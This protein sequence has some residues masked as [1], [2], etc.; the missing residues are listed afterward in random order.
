V[1]YS[2]YIDRVRH[3]RGK[4]F[5]PS[6]NREEIDR[7]ELSINLALRGK[8]VVVVSSG[9]PG[10]FAMAS[11]IFEVVDK[12]SISKEDLPIVV[13]PG[14]TALLAASARLGAP[15][16]HDFC[17]INLSD[18]LK[19]W[20][21]IKSRVIAAAKAD[22][23]I[24]FY[25]PRSKSRENQLAEIYNILRENC[26]SDRLVI[27]ANSVSTKSEAIFET[28]LSKA[29]ASLVSMKTLVIIGSSSTKKIRN[30]GYIYTPRYSGLE[31]N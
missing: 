1:G 20:D 25:N 13:L 16:G 11:A 26:N 5:H 4:S 8:K 6:D 9:D 30:T 3:A 22:F 27:Y 10:V 12:R 28:T 2:K 29:D 19:S 21:I 17:V 15:I 7:A 24:A 18:N 14:I 23:V 31:K